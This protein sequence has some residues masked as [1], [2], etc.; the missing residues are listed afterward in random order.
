MVLVLLGMLGI[1]V[2]NAGKLADYV[3]EKIG[4]TVVLSDEIKD[5]DVIRLQ[6]VLNAMKFVKSSRFIDK[7]AAAK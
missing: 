3:R 6:K 2:I 5:V 1:I 4:F 7:E